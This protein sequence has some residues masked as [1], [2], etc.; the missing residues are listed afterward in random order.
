[1]LR[2]CSTKH[3]AFLAPFCFNLATFLNKKR[4]RHEV[5]EKVRKCSESYPFR[6]ADIW[7]LFG[8]VLAHF[9]F[10]LATFC[11]SKVTM[12]TLLMSATIQLRR[13]GLHPNVLND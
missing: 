2:K 10:D 12:D 3:G 1:M 8:P 6:L 11:L 4:H 7:L 13:R 9:C 5:S